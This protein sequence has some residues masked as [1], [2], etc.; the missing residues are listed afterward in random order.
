MATFVD[1]QET[2][3]PE[4]KKQFLSEVVKELIETTRKVETKANS[5]SIKP[6]L[7][8]RLEIFREAAVITGK[9]QFLI[10]LA[11]IF[12]EFVRNPLPTSSDAS[13][14]ARNLSRV[15]EGQSQN[16]KEIFDFYR[17]SQKAKLPSS[18]QD[19]EYTTVCEDFRQPEQDILKGD[20]LDSIVGLEEPKEDLKN[21]LVNPLAF[22]KLFSDANR[23]ILLTG[24]PGTGKTSLVRATIKFILETQKNKINIILYTPSTSQLTSKYKN[25]SAKLVDATFRCAQKAAQALEAKEK[26][27]AIAVIFLDEIDVLVGSREGNQDSEDTKVVNSF[28]QV[29]DGINTYEN[30]YLV[31]ATNLVSKIDS[32]ILRR[33]GS[34]VYVGRPTKRDL[35]QILNK[36][37]SKFLNSRIASDD[38]ELI[39]FF[40]GNLDDAAIQHIADNAEKAY[41][42]GSDIG[43]IFEKAVD[44]LGNRSTKKDLFLKFQTK[45]SKVTSQLSTYYISI[46]SIP[47]EFWFP[48]FRFSVKQSQPVLYRI[49]TETIEWKFS[50]LSIKLPGNSTPTTYTSSYFLP[51]IK[52][53][54]IGA[55]FGFVKFPEYTGI[56]V[57]QQTEDLLQSFVKQNRAIRPLLDWYTENLKQESVELIMFY[58]LFITNDEAAGATKFNELSKQKGAFFAVTEGDN[59]EFLYVKTYMFLRTYI[60]LALDDKT[61]PTSGILQTG[62][63][64]SFFSAAGRY[65]RYLTSALPD[66]K[67][68]FGGT[69]SP[70]KQL[71]NYREIVRKS[72][73]ESNIS[74]S[75][76]RFTQN[77]GIMIPGSGS[78]SVYPCLISNTPIFLPES[79][80]QIQP[81]T[82]NY[83]PSVKFT[84]KDGVVSVENVVSKFFGNPNS[85]LEFTALHSIP[86]ADSNTDRYINLNLDAYVIGEQVLKKLTGPQEK[87]RMEKIQSIEKAANVQLV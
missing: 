46:D 21:T 44:R 23:N 27:R 66:L 29:L 59:N 81:D 58:P 22:P 8:D 28:L 64:Q 45:S 71:L 68:F 7:E 60:K 4:S 39:K 74:E 86:V 69:S 75:V 54:E 10:Q 32:G 84:P 50:Q 14:F 82:I 18:A 30:V 76:D 87:A 43:S 62:T 3:T 83:V 57:V 48:I 31:G 1:F 85:Q 5:R 34:P 47:P 11:Q 53:S 77:I 17:Q 78:T 25:E 72:F 38:V 13:E 80:T 49:S 55:S 51:F 12:P 41:L 61:E 40:N 24:P 67:G 6:S 65:G 33:F 52:P 37:L 35:V 2:V 56:P 20:S 9:W 26:G 73:E 16:F 42:T 63:A 36:R 70:S 15:G 19:N 79:K